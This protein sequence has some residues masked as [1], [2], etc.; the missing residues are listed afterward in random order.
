MCEECSQCLGYIGFAPAHGICAFLVYTAQVPGCSAGV[1]SKADPVFHALL[2]S[3]PLSFRFSGTPQGHILGWA[4]ILCPSQVRGAQATRCLVSTLSQVCGASCHLPSPS[5]SVS[6]VR[7]KN[8][9]SGV[10][11]VSSGELI[12][13]CDPPGRCQP[14]RIPGRHS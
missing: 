2:R 10:P 13:D 6:W 1:L 14:S 11:C 9:I 8:A 4:C 5:P 12:S 3:K 7:H